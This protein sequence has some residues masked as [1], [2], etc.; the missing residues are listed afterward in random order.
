MD[1]SL[2][3][4]R[5]NIA[6][7]TL[8]GILASFVVAGTANAAVAT[9]VYG[10]VTGTE[11]YSAD[12]QWGLDNGILDESQ[13]YFRAGDNATRAEFFKMT[14]AGAGIPEAACD[15]TL[16]PDLN[17]DHWGCG[18]VTALAEAGVVSGDGANAA[19]PGYVRP[20]DNIVRAEAGKVVVEAYG[21][22]G[23]S[24]GTVF[25]DV[26][27]TEWYSDYAGI[28]FDNCVFQGVGSTMNLEG[29]RNIVR[30][31]AIAVVHRGANPTSDCQS[32]VGPTGALTVSVDGST[33]AS[34][35]I[36]RN[37]SGVSYTVWGLQA[38]NDED[39]NIE[40]L[41]VHR[42]GLGEAN[43][44]K[45]VRLYVNGV[46][47]GSKKNVNTTSN[48]A[49]FALAG[50]VITVPAGGKLLVEAVADMDTLNSN[51]ENALCLM[52]PE[53]VTAVG[54]D[55]GEPVVVG[56]AFTA[57][58][59]YMYT[60]SATVGTVQYTTTDFGGDINVGDTD[61]DMTRLRL[62]VDGEAGMIQ[63]ITMKQTGSADPEDFANTMW[64]HNNVA[65]DGLDCGWA[66]DFWSCDFTGA[67]QTVADGGVYNLD[68]RTDVV[69]GI[70]NT[71]AFDVKRDTDIYVLGDQ[72]HYGLNVSEAT[73]STA[74]AARNI[75]GGRLAFSTSADNPTVGDVA[76]NANDHEFLGF[77]ISTGGD[78]VDI[79]QFDLVVTYDGL[80]LAANE[81]DDLKVWKW[82]KGT[83]SWKIAAS[84][85]DP[86]NGTCTLW[87]VPATCT[88]TYE[89]VISLPASGTTQFMATMDVD[90]NAPDGATYAV[91]MN[92]LATGDAEFSSNGDPVSTTEISGLPLAGNAQT[93][94]PPN[95]TVEKS[96]AP[97]DQTVVK[98]QKAIDLVGYDLT[99]STASDLTFR[100]LELTCVPSAGNCDDYFTNLELYQKDGASLFFLDNSNF[101]GQV[102]VFN[103][104]NLDIANGQ[105]E[106]IL[107]R[108][109]ATSSPATGVTAT[110][111]LA[112]DTD[113]AA[114]D[115]FGYALSSGAIA[116]QI[117][118]CVAGGEGCLTPTTEAP[119]IS[120]ASNG[121]IQVSIEDTLDDEIVLD[122]TNDV[123]VGEVTI[124]ETSDAEGIL[125]RKL[126]L[127]NNID[128][129]GCGTSGVSTVKIP[130][131]DATNP[132]TAALQVSGISEFSFATTGDRKVSVPRDGT[133][134]LPIYVNTNTIGGSGTTSGEC[135]D[136]QVNLLNGVDFSYDAGTI[137]IDALGTSSGVQ[138]PTAD[139]VGGAGYTGDVYSSGANTFTIR[140]NKPSITTNYEL[141][142]G[143]D[144]YGF[145]QTPSASDP[146][147]GFNVSVEGTDTMSM[148]DIEL[149]EDGTCS[150]LATNVLLYRETAY[151]ANQAAL[152][153]D[154]GDGVF[155]AAD[156]T[157]GVGIQVTG[158]SDRNYVVVAD[159][160]TGGCVF[161]TTTP[162]TLEVWI[163]DNGFDADYDNDANAATGDGPSAFIWDDSKVN[164]IPGQNAPWIGDTGVNNDT[165]NADTTMIF[166]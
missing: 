22:T 132:Y 12:V 137:D 31:E 52:A 64:Y 128:G 116:D 126:R 108:A 66:G 125:I 136:M 68:L 123:L 60:T 14:A 80:S 130:Y 158:G 61:V 48:D 13:A 7:F 85:L 141:T 134:T 18:W 115:E 92:P 75:V 151:L 113:I 29:G 74:P 133:I 36:P 90:A 95:L 83:E 87:P 131:P 49:D 20:N 11:W 139:I 157:N 144:L 117:D 86:A 72:Y 120:F 16:F 112:A 100:T 156:F 50:D 105:T 45:E 106:K 67:N 159:T 129:V 160:S 34:S 165:V 63:R 82:D 89:D 114:D 163:G 102:A 41:L 73:G 5:K 54:A 78:S 119:V 33:P 149:S 97:G 148:Y 56:G 77:N 135:V 15:E 38:S 1:L 88:N 51:S 47:K 121:A 101:S 110:I 2:R 9:D 127:T 76:P 57:C 154:G 107:A 91:G 79:N 32:Y 164:L 40:G 111:E 8:L 23:S 161:N 71:A 166:G 39:V 150:A 65:V 96:S 152:A 147:L 24:P 153:D 58:G 62:E 99:A 69:G 10:D 146:V 19:T 28:A 118:A 46:Q 93:V 162:D 142:T 109:D 140:N 124:R 103:N 4:I 53:S 122:G 84:G 27:G 94:A 43:D 70:A 98:N 138:L 81:V 55:S 59:N 155:D 37:A 17:A 35:L 44:F 25:D 26:A 6:A 104:V 42:T 30:A 145:G 3:N 21:L 143:Q